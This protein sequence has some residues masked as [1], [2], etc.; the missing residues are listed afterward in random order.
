MNYSTAPSGNSKGQR[1]FK[2]VR[3]LKFV[4]G[5]KTKDGKPRKH[6]KPIA[7]AT[8]NKMSIFFNYLTYWKELDIRHAIDDMHVQKNVF[9]SI[10]G[11]LL[12]MKGKTKEGL[13]SRLDMVHLG[14]KKELHPIL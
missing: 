7:G 8:F 14:I 10:I 1:V 13:N 2:I 4:F 3:K 9:E 12:D 11:T 6:V 5:K